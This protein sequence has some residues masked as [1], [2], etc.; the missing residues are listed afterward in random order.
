VTLTTRVDLFYNSLVDIL[1]IHGNYLSVKGGSVA[2]A[3]AE[4]E[5]RGTH[6]ALDQLHQKLDR[7]ER[8]YELLQDE[9]VEWER[10]L[11]DVRATIE[12]LE[13]KDEPRDD[14]GDVL[15]WVDKANAL[16]RPRWRG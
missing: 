7:Y 3:A 15:D 8:A 12:D 1:R 6:G 2:K 10:E 16:Y 5:V 11:D 4:Y 13:G 14:I 9:L